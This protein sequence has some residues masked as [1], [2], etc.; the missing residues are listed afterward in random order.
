MKKLIVILGPTASGKSELA[1]KLAKRFSGEIVSADSRQVYRGLDIGTGKVTRKEMRRIPHHLL[2]VASP[3]KRY[4]VARYQK[5]ARKAILGIHK[6]GRLPF[7]VG[8]SPLYVYAVV[9]GWIMPEVRPQT[10][11]RKELGKLSINEL[12]KKLKELDP[13]RARTIEQKNKRRLI[14]ALEIILITGKPVPSLQKDSLPYPSLFIGIKKSPQVLQ[15]K[16]RK[17]F[18]LMLK[19]GFL[20]EIKELRKQG[21][22][23]KRIESFG[24]EYRE[25]SQYLQ[26]KITRQEMIEK[27]LKATQ[28]FARRQM[29]WFKKDPRIHWVKNQREAENLVRLSFQKAL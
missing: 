6:R 18:L 17:R 24:F 20:N 9:D 2:S 25:V 13:H 21:L 19:H 26:K 22:S 29:T 5:E 14:R 4:T 7:L 8:G 1:I 23:W 10:K 11:L 3:K 15:Q 12:Y 16:I 27:T 28:D